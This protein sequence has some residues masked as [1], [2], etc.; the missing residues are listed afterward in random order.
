MSIP[1]LMGEKRGHPFSL[2]RDPLTHPGVNAD[3]MRQPKHA[4]KSLR[5]VFRPCGHDQNAHQA[6]ARADVKL[7][8]NCFIAHI[9][10][11]EPIS[12]PNEK[13]SPNDSTKTF[14]LYNFS[15]HFMCAI[16]A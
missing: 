13:V 2:P 12:R 9:K 10:R 14:G 3:P 5:D 6:A 8:T 1:T 4:K 7:K 11:P 16:I 15:A